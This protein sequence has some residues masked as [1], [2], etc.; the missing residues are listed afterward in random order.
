MCLSDVVYE[1]EGMVVFELREGVLCCGCGVDV[2]RV[3]M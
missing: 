2:E 3:R 1:L